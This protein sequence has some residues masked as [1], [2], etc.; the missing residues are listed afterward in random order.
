MHLLNETLTVAT[1]ETR[2][3]FRSNKWWALAALY[4]TFSLFSGLVVH[5]CS[6]LVS[7]NVEQQ[8]EKLKEQAGTSEGVD[9][10]IDMQKRRA[11]TSFVLEFFSANDATL[12][13]SLVVI[14]MPFLFIFELGLFFLPLFIALLGFDQLASEYDSRSLRFLTIRAR[15]ESLVLGRFLSQLFLVFTLVSFCLILQLLYV[16]LT[17][18]ELD[19][20]SWWH[21]SFRFALKAWVYCIPYVALTTL[22]SSMGKTGATA[23]FINLFLL[24]F[25]W[26]LASSDGISSAAWAQWPQYASIWH[27]RTHLL[28]PE[29]LPLSISV[30]AHIL[31]GGLFLAGGVWRLQT[32]DV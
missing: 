6:N 5:G 21:L 17:S 32:R 31:F 26:L 27:H 3:A 18:H 29:W 7:R 19:L 9:A 12:A 4:L 30:G 14:P 1:A 2:R 25:F 15:R 23:L 11:R 16:K 24:F 20:H 22:S 8:T 10:L 28:H 13:E